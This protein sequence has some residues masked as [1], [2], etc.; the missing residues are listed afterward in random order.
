MLAPDGHPREYIGNG[1]ERTGTGEYSRLD[2]QRS[3]V[4]VTG[5]YGRRA[6][7]SC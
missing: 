2:Q 3:L 6:E 4:Q 7:R 5:L 1:L